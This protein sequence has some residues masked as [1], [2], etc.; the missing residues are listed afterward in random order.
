MYIEV[1]CA[2]RADGQGIAA[3]VR[4]QGVLAGSPGN[5]RSEANVHSFRKSGLNVCHPCRV[6]LKKLNEQPQP[7][8]AF[9]EFTVWLERQKR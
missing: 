9:H 4:L 7:L 5:T 8:A 2:V 6:A 1:L 3:L